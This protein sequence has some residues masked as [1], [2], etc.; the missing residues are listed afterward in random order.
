MIRRFLKI[1][2]IVLLIICLLSLFLLRSYWN[3]EKTSSYL[4]EKEDVLD[5]V[6]TDVAF[7]DITM[8]GITL[9]RIEIGL[10]GNIVPR[11]VKNFMAL[12]QGFQIELNGKEGWIG[13]KGTTFHRVIKDF[14][15]QGGNITQDNRTE[16]ISV[17]GGIFPDENFLLTHQ[18]EGWVSMANKGPN[19]N[20]CQF[21]ITLAPTP[22]LD[23]HHVVFGKVFKGMEIVRTIGAEETK[24]EQPVSTIK[25]V[26]SGARE[27]TETESGLF[28]K[29]H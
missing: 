11:T 17:F 13:Y 10:F 21:F 9:G 20:A 18:S 3:S 22:W 16:N 7:F 12:A 1:K 23:A 27:P 14:M 4:E 5:L 28:A 24:D 6:V 29:L 2:N 26:H 25:I 8:G 15:I 19:T